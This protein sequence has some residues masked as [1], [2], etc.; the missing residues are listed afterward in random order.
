R[1]GAGAGLADDRGVHADRRLHPERRLVQVE[2]QAQDG[3]GPGPGALAGTAG[4]GSAEER[5]HDVLEPDERAGAATGATTARAQRIAP[6]VDDLPLLRVGQDLVGGVDLLELVLSR[7][8]RVDVGVELPGE[9]TIGPLDVVRR[10][11]PVYPQ[12]AVVVLGHLCPKP[13]SAHS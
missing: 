5:V 3:V 6:E 1:T 9:L 2:F 12:D 11:V 10:G 13:L 7:R 4:R 8:V